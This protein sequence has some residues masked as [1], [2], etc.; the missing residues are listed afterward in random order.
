[1]KI[2]HKFSFQKFLLICSFI[3]L[4]GFFAQAQ[5]AKYVFFFIGDGMGVAH[6]AATE[7]YLQAVDHDYGSEK[8]TFTEFPV[9]GL[10]TTYADNRFITGSAA[11][12]TALATGHKTTIGTISMDPAKEKPL[13]TIAEQA[14][15]EGFKIGI[16]SSVSIDHATPAAF[17][18]H[19]PE[20][21]MYHE[22]ALD[23]PKSGFDFFGG[24]GF[25]NPFGGEG[26]ASV[27]D[28]LAEKGY[29]LAWTKPS[30]EALKKGDEKVVAT[31]SILESSGA[32]R[33]AIDQTEEDIPLEAFVGKAIEL[34]DNDRGFFI[35]CE[36]GKIDW[37]SHENDGKTVIENV[38]SL[39]K[40]VDEAME[41]YREH[42]DET[43]I[44]V[45]ADHETGGM[46]LGHVLS[47]YDTDYAHLATQEI[48]AQNFTLLAD[49]LFND[50]RNQNL[51]FAMQLVEDYFGLGGAIGLK[52][53]DYEKGLLEEAYFASTGELDMDKD[54]AYV[55]YGG[56]Y[57]LAATAIRILN[58]KAGLAW[59]TWSHTG[60]PVPVYAIGAGAE[61]FGGKYD[62][63]DIPEKIA[64][65]MGFEI[66][67]NQSKLN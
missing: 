65:S 16:I 46:T 10:S 59:T 43:L 35:M 8:L 18:A 41:F 57:P 29:T 31:G 2:M 67:N 47:K 20:R 28:V 12:G 61:L 42:P 33:Y 36:E 14:K 34:L 39:S 19:Q 40:S 50:K 38:I 53:S 3:I 17:Y 48:S 11:A 37:A 5:Q 30:F 15:Q 54:E 32:L 52:L 1:M 62:N 56:Y 22:I 4:S 58:N 24:G 21:G 6:V 9:T 60:I 13:K 26:N 63:T 66:D 64:K 23:L 55:R 7:A 49:S 51:G 25:K 45:T 27:Y 44:I